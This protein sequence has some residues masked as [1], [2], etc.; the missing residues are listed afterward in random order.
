M[1]MSHA[2]TLMLDALRGTTEAAIYRRASRLA[3]LPAFG[4]SAANTIRA[5]LISELY[6]QG[7]TGD[8]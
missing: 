7:R 4:V 5:P 3:M 2:H 1:I 6:S 8:L